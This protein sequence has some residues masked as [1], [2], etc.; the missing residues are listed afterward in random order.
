MTDQLTPFH[1][2]SLAITFPDRHTQRD[3]HQLGLSGR[4]C[5]PADDLLGEDINDERH[6]GPPRPGAHIDIP[7]E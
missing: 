6:I 4:R 3:I 5:V 1:R 2:V 7:R